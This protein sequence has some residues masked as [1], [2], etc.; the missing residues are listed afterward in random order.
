MTESVR[1]VNDCA[2]DNPL[3]CRV[4]AKA[5]NTTRIST[6]IDQYLRGLRSVERATFDQIPDNF[7]SSVLNLGRFGQKIQRPKI[8]K[9]AGNNVRIVTIAQTIPIAPTGPSPR[10]FVSCDNK[11]TRR[12]RATVDPEATIGSTT[13]RQAIFIAVVRDSY[14]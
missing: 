4:V 11:S 12:P 1:V 13:P 7:S 3:E 2:V 8:T 14:L 5:A 10:L 9:R 6:A